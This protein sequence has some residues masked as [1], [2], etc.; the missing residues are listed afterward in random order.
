M[1][2][3]IIAAMALTF[4]SNISAIPLSE[5]LT[6]DNIPSESSEIESAE[7]ATVNGTKKDL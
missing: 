3:S 5:L 7:N 1:C 6:A 2:C 4:N